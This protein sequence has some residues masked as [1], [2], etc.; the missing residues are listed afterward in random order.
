MLALGNKPKKITSLGNK[1]NMI[2][3]LGRKMTPLLESRQISLT[4]RNPVSTLHGNSSNN[5][6]MAYE[7]L[8]LKP[9]PKSSSSSLQI[10]KSKKKHRKDKYNQF[11]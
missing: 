10:E 9:V 8:G 11:A 2:S 5:S 3:T 7:P 1:S 6:E 4:Q